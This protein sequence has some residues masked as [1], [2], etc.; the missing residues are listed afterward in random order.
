MSLSLSLSVCLS[1]CTHSVHHAY[2]IWYVQCN[3]CSQ[4]QRQND[5]LNHVTNKSI[6]RIEAATK[7]VIAVFNNNFAGYQKTSSENNS[8]S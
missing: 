4:A 5:V 1:L 8:F 2:I 3:V 6:D 7:S